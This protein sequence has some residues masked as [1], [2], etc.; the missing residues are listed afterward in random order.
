M[1]Y[2]RYKM[3]QKY[4]SDVPQEEYR[5]GDLISDTV[6]STLEECNEGNLKPDVPVDGALYHWIE[7]GDI[8]CENGDKYAVEKQQIS[9]DNG[10]TWTDTGHIRQGDLIAAH[11]SD[12]IQYRWIEKADD[13]ICLLSAKH[14]KEIQQISVDNGVTWSDT[15]VMR[16]GEVI[17][18]SSTDCDYESKYLTFVILENM[19]IYVHDVGIYYSKDNGNS[20]TRKE[21]GEYIDARAGERILV[22]GTWS[23]VSENGRFDSGGRGKCI[24]EGNVMSLLYGDEFVGKTT[25]DSYCS[26]DSLFNYYDYGCVNIISAENLVL[27]ATDLQPGCYYGMFN[28]CSELVTAPTILPA[29]TLTDGCYRR[30]FYHCTKLKNIPVLPATTL[31]DYC[32]YEMFDGCSSLSQVPELPAT[33]MQSRCYMMMF[34]GCSNIDTAPELP[35]MTLAE[36]CYEQMFQNC[37]NLINPPA[38]PATTLYEG[39][40]A[41]MFDGCKNLIS[42]PDLYALVLARGCYNHMFANCERLQYVKALFTSNPTP[43]SQNNGT[44]WTWLWLAN[45]SSNGTFVKNGEATWTDRGNNSIPKNWSIIIN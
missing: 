8:M 37:I 32:Y 3:L 6:I 18:A 5:V 44:G 26:L 12:C 27:P 11:S 7:N 4:I 36:Y 17:E 40:Y 21:L 30:M 39:C 31:A 34:L 19:L 22:K 29:T 1:S 33:T 41:G 42:A 28:G 45:V 10:V 13:Y 2:K 15:E 14:K 16:A 24:V 20:W 43:Q 35:A 23:T 9:E 38:L 25:M